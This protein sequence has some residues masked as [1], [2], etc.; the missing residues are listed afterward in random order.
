MSNF[1]RRTAVRVV[2]IAAILFGV[3]TAIVGTRALLGAGPGYVIYLPLLRFNTIMG[4]AYVAVGVVAW[5]DLKLGVY[6]A[7]AIAVLNL[8][9]LAFVIHL[10]TPNGSIAMESLRAM[11]FRTG[12]WLVFFAGLAWANRGRLK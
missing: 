12:V 10:Y 4:F 8:V 1:H 7:A 3:L 11:T 6:G 2:A 5:R 9:A